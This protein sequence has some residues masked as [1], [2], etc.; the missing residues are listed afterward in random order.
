MTLGLRPLRSVVNGTQNFKMFG[1]IGAGIL[2]ER[3]E[4]PLVVFCPSFTGRC[5]LF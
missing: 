5:W 2:S 4:L 1:F 3:M